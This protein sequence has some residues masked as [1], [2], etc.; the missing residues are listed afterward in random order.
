LTIFAGEGA[1]EIQRDKNKF[2]F[3]KE[4]RSRL[5][6]FEGSISDFN[7]SEKQLKKDIDEDLDRRDGDIAKENPFEGKPQAKQDAPMPMV[8]N[9]GNTVTNNET[10]APTLVKEINMTDSDP[11]IKSF[12]NAKDFSFG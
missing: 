1:D 7:L 8:I 10:I 9:S 3:L 2:R 6:S 4:Q 12:A 11:F 5:K